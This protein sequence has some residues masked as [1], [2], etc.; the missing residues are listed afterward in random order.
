MDCIFCRIVAGTVP[1]RVVRE[2]ADTLAFHDLDP[3]AP[4]HVLVVP[5]RHIAS[6]NDG[7]EDDRAVMGALFLAAR[8]VA[9][10][11]NIAASGYRVV[12][13]TGPDA[14]QTVPHVHVHV[15]GGRPLGWPPG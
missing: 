4:V 7:R 8:D 3:K 10:T 15:L 11:E 2:D 14:N 9:V 12:V 6:L 1:A 5:K 13:N